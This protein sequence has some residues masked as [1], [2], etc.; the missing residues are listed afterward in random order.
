MKTYVGVDVQIQ[1][2][3]TWALVRGEWPA[4]RL[5]NFTPGKSPPTHWLGDWVGN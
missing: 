5:D 3:L 4:S 2:F 1:V